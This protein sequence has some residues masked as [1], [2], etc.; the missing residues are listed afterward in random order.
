LV[1]ALVSLKKY[2]QAADNGYAHAMRLEPVSSEYL[3]G[4]LRKS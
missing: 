1:A 2:Q 4:E 3:Q